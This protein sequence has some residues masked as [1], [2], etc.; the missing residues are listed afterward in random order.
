MIKERTS[1]NQQE[2]QTS[3]ADLVND[4]EDA[5]AAL[6]QA[7]TRLRLVTNRLVTLH[8]RDPEIRASLAE[9]GWT[10]QTPFIPSEDDTPLF[11]VVERAKLVLGGAQDVAM[12]PV[13]S[14]MTETEFKIDC[15][16]I[17]DSDTDSPHH[18]R[19]NH[20]DPEMKM[21]DL[22]AALSD[23]QKLVS[24]DVDPSDFQIPQG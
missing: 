16:F 9:A 7:R 15:L 2:G 24:M 4:L 21:K 18:V 11:D 19:V 12:V 17:N 1:M 6:Q 10:P 13:V 14:K 22:I 8:L 20:I 3:R 5:K 23:L